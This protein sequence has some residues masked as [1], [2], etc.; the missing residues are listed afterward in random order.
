MV[1]KFSKMENFLFK[2]NLLLKIT[3]GND[4]EKIYYVPRHYKVTHATSRLICVGYGM[5]LVM[6]RSINE[7]HA[8]TAMAY[9]HKNILTECVYIDGMSPMTTTSNSGTEWYYTK[10]GEKIPFELPWHWKQPDTGS[11]IERCLNLL[12]YSNA[13]LAN[14]GD[15][16]QINSFI[17]ERKVVKTSS[18]ST[19][20]REIKE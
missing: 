8:V 9:N 19:T 4:F 17:C 5:D 14:D 3:E 18:S 1:C 13:F 15:C 2:S 6:I 7:F 11:G 20:P 12:L 16:N 10:T